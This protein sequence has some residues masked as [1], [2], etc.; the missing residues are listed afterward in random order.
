MIYLLPLALIIATAA[1]LT[2][3]RR[4]NGINFDGSFVETAMQPFITEKRQLNAYNV[5]GVFEVKSPPLA[6]PGVA[7]RHHGPLLPYID[8][9]KIPAPVGGFATALIRADTVNTPRPTGDGS[10]QFRTVCTFSHMNFDDAIVYP[11][12][13]GASHLH[14][15]FGNTAADYTSTKASIETSGGSTCSG[16]TANRTGYWVPAIID[17]KDGT[18]LKPDS[19]MV[20]YKTGYIDGDNVQPFPAGLRFIAGDMK[21]TGPQVHNQWLCTSPTGDWQKDYTSIPTNC[22]VGYT[23]TANINFPFCWDGVNLDSPDHKSHMSWHVWNGQRSVCPATH[24]VELPMISENIKYKVTR[25]GAPARWRLASDNYG[26]DKPGGYSL[27]A[28]WFN[29]W[30]AKVQALW[31]KNCLQANKD[32]GVDVLG[33]GTRL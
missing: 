29:G 31:I 11:G 5:S 18:P 7:A 26:T 15:Y 22:P 21:S 17:T 2:L 4:E 25:A 28:D 27:H 13:K 19:I 23:I 16:G 9:L 8:M 10:G 1:A 24:P 33:T 30:D 14:T 32:C 6:L 12:Q 20:Y 3:E